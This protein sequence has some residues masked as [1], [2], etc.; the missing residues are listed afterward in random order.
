MHR[1]RASTPGTVK[2]SSSGAKVLGCVGGGSQPQLY[3]P[4]YLHYD[5]DS[6][7]DFFVQSMIRVTCPPLHQRSSRNRSHVAVSEGSSTARQYTSSF[8]FDVRLLENM[9][10]ILERELVESERSIHVLQV[11]KP[12]ADVYDSVSSC[13]G[14]T[15]DSV[16]HVHLGYHPLTNQLECTC[17]QGIREAERELKAVHQLLELVK[18]PNTSP[19]DFQKCF[20]SDDNPPVASTVDASSHLSDIDIPDSTSVAIAQQRSAVKEHKRPPL[21]GDRTSPSRQGRRPEPP[22]LSPPGRDP[23]SSSG[24]TQTITGPGK[25]PVQAESGQVA[26]EHF[27]SYSSPEQ[28]YALLPIDRVLPLLARIYSEYHTK[29]EENIEST[30]SSTGSGGKCVAGKSASVPKDRIRSSQDLNENVLAENLGLGVFV[31]SMNKSNDT[32]DCCAQ[33]IPSDCVLRLLN[34]KSMGSLEHCG[35]GTDDSVLRVSDVLLQHQASLLQVY[36]YWLQKRLS[37]AQSNPYA[38][39]LIRGYHYYRWMP[40]WDLQVGDSMPPPAYP[41]DSLPTNPLGASAEPVSIRPA[42]KGRPRKLPL[43]TASPSSLLSRANV[44]M[45][46]VL[47][48]DLDRSRLIVDRLVRRE[49]TKRELSRLSSEAVQDAIECYSTDANVSVYRN[50]KKKFKKAIVNSQDTSMKSKEKLLLA[51]EMVG[52]FL[53]DGSSGV[54]IVDGSEEVKVAQVTSE[55]P[56]AEVLTRTRLTG[57]LSRRRLKQQHANSSNRSSPR[58]QASEVPEKSNKMTKLQRM[59]QLLS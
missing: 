17:M 7:D 42:T 35:T 30:S 50:G 34:K 25:I 23:N 39:S 46:H 58:C 27:P 19:L 28:L 24:T 52:S 40:N 4:P 6:D 31:D 49:K 10:T 32:Y 48:N 55:R 5:A 22:F 20:Q 54:G 21:T 57:A 44:Y 14:A 51:R 16:S 37:V 18:L 12:A 29:R 43:V 9:I 59:L 41:D 45:R 26:A 15:S 2:S 47:R 38:V 13:A 53:P 33:V 3:R 8:L 36:D 56:P 11:N 1:S